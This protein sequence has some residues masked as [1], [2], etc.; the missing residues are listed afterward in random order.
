MATC[1]NVIKLAM[2][3][4]LQ[5]IYHVF[6]IFK[7]VWDHIWHPHVPYT[8]QS[9][10]KTPPSITSPLYT[11]LHHN[12]RSS[13]STKYELR[14]CIHPHSLF[15]TATCALRPLNLYRYWWVVFACHIHRLLY[16]STIIF[17]AILLYLGYL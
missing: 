7:L 17:V 2:T 8:N 5:I 6:H 3:N 11:Y 4:E 1:H 16:Y 14:A 12:S 10:T 13:D 9:T 15:S